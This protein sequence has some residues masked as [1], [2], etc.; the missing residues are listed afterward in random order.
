MTPTSLPERGSVRPRRYD[1]PHRSSPKT[2]IPLPWLNW[3]L[4]TLIPASRAMES[5]ASSPPDRLLGET[6]ER[7]I[8]NQQSELY[9]WRYK[10]C[11]TYLACSLQSTDSQL[12]KN[13]RVTERPVHV[14]DSVSPPVMILEELHKPFSLHQQVHV[15]P[16]QYDVQL[17]CRR[18]NSILL[19]T[20]CNGLRHSL[21]PPVTCSTRPSKRFIRIW[22]PHS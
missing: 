11:S 22:D 12:T 2:L 3:Y 17:E 16:Q 10:N 7:G 8:W 18:S 5:F 4:G 6:P 19:G 1:Q 14:V 13:I 21:Q 20:Y 9:V 15:S